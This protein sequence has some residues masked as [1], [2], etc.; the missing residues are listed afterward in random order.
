[1]SATIRPKFIQIAVTSGGEVGVDVLYALDENGDV[2][3]CT[4]AEREGDNLYVPTTGV[5]NWEPLPRK[6]DTTP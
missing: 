5:P 4:G 6:R 2:W 3:W 1:M